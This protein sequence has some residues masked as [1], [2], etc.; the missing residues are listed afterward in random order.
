MAQS[1]VSLLKLQLGQLDMLGHP[2]VHSVQ[3]Q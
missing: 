2:L 1:V 3:W